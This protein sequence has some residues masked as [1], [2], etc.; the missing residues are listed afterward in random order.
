MKFYTRFQQKTKKARRVTILLLNKK[1]FYNVNTCGLAF[2][3]AYARI[4][5]GFGIS[6]WIECSPK[7]VH[8]CIYRYVQLCLDSG[9]FAFFIYQ[10]SLKHVL[11]HA[12]WFRCLTTKWH[13]K[14]QTCLLWLPAFGEVIW[15]A[16]TKRLERLLDSS[17]CC[18]KWV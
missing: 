1:Y 10:L 16:S 9:L 3:I 4:S 18:V 15:K 7:D 12:A 5:S 6:I 2:I 17:I 13:C 8:V 14:F 11:T